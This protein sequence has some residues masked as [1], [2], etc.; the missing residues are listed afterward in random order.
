[1]FTISI[2]G[3]IPPVNKHRKALPHVCARRK[4]V[5]KLPNLRRAH[6]LPALLSERRLLSADLKTKAPADGPQLPSHRDYKFSLRFIIRHRPPFLPSFPLML[7]FSTS[8]SSA[9]LYSINF[10]YSSW[11]SSHPQFPYSKFCIAGFCIFLVFWGL[12]SRENLNP[13]RPFR[14]TERRTLPT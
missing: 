6:D 13:W 5:Q 8:S 7:S 10:G 14:F 9:E 2:S 12:M 11:S 4:T 1:M 3:D